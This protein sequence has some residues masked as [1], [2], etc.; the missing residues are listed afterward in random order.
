MGSS[1]KRGFP[2]KLFNSAAIAIAAVVF[3]AP[4]FAQSPLSDDEARKIA[5]DIA[6]KCDAAYNKH[7]AAGVAALYAKNGA[8]VPAR[9]ARLFGLFV[10]GRHAIEK[11]FTGEFNEFGNQEITINDAGPLSEGSMWYIAGVHLSG[12]GKNGPTSIDGV[13]VATLVRDGSDWEYRMT[14]VTLRPKD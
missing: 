5:A 1:Y 3:V 4:A 7:D 2:M 9:R 6:A 10:T 13:Q 11:F 14:T 8:L 12:Q